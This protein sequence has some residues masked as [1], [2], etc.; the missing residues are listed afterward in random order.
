MGCEAV[1]APNQKVLKP[2]E[3]ER[4][5]IEKSTHILQQLNDEFSDTAKP[6][7]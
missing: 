6:N 3:D 7:V 1:V 2:I 5:L 4:E